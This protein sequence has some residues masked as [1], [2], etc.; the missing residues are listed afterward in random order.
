M[1]KLSIPSTNKFGLAFENHLEPIISKEYSFQPKRLFFTMISEVSILLINFHQRREEK[2][3]S[4]LKN[5][6][7]KIGDDSLLPNTLLSSKSVPVS[8]EIREAVLLKLNAFE[9]QKGYLST[10]IN[11]TSLAKFLET[12]SSYLSKIINNAKGKSFKNYLNDLRIEYAYEELKNNSQ[13]RKFTIEANA[14]DFGFKSAESFSKKFKT[15]Y[16]V[17]PSKFIKGLE[18]LS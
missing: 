18:K 5:L 9:F 2:Y 3:R 16:G 17:Y 15:T 14:F 11:L 4:I 7:H 1:D 6:H 10:T 8:K 13:K 12:N